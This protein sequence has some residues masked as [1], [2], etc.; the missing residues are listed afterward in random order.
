MT[1][2]WSNKQKRSFQT[3]ISGLKIGGA[4]PLALIA[5][6]CVIESE[7][8]L[9]GIAGAIKSI[10][11]KLNIPFILKASYDK[12]NRT[13]VDS[14]RGPGLEE[15]LKIL[16]SVK[17]MFD[18]PALTDVH[19]I[20]DVERVASAADII[21]IP[22]FL[23]RQTDLITEVSRTG[24]TVNVKKGQFLSPWDMEYVIEKITKS[25]NDKILITERGTCF[26]YNNL[27][28]DFRSLEIISNFG[29]PVIFDATHSVQL[30]GGAK[31]CSGGDRDFVPLLSRAAVA[32]GCDG[33]FLEVHPE[34]DKALCDG[35]NSLCLDDLEGLLIKVKDINRIVKE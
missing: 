11:D 24:K 27:V 29:Y 22:A 16:K 18:V 14:Y 25:G 32:A 31:G 7:K 1:K 19:N 12:A 23:S 5:G 13:S 35:P 28:V 26:G 4:N 17:G 6:P 2:D 10:T 34:P 21:Q 30:P 9:A 15:G 33:L 20:Q 8:N 3:I